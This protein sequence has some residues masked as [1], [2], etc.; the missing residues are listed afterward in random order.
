MREKHP[1]GFFVPNNAKYLILG[2]FV[3][4]SYIHDQK[5]DWYYC[6]KRNQF[7]QIIEKTYKV[8]LPDKKAKQKLFF[9]LGIA[10]GDIIKDCD[11]T[12]SNSA[13]S[14]LKNIIYNLKEVEK[15]L[16]RNKIKKIFFTSR[17]VEKE[18][19]KNFKALIKKYP[20]IDLI[21]LPSPSPRYAAID[22][23]NKA[24]FYTRSLPKIQNLNWLGEP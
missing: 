16:S 11:R 6:S 20:E 22:I 23:E 12:K 8:K 2:S 17:F 1:F 21:T 7:W 13:D 10:M 9:T 19:K 5:Y 4:N 24:I 18:Y 15:V 14:S 3:A